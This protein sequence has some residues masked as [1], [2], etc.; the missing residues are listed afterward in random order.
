[1]ELTERDMERI[2]KL[3]GS[4]VKLL[5]L[6]VTKGDVYIITN[7]GD[8]WVEFSAQKFYPNVLPIL[9]KVKIISARNEYESKYPGESRKWKIFTFLNLQKNMDIQLVTNI[10]CLGDSIIELDAGKIL[11]SKFT[12]AY[13]KTIKF[14][15][16]PKP[17]ELN[18]QL[19]LV[20]VQFNAIVSAVKNL[21]IRVEKKKK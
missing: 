10:I 21:T 17:E 20:T 6:A 19:N 9:K 3:E 14:K 1:M 5:E 18:K 2:S 15:E 12:Q 8:G 11:A 16:S 4:V 7:A 13:I